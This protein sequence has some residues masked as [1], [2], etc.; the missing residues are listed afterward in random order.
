MYITV[1]AG[2]HHG[3]HFTPASVMTIGSAHCEVVGVERPF[4]QRSVLRN[5]VYYESAAGTTLGSP[6]QSTYPRAR[7]SDA[8]WTAGI[9]MYLTH[10]GLFPQLRSLLPQWSRRPSVAAMS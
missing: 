9:G 8:G 4:T 10:Q 3:K 5:A 1:C 7:G 2:L 6:A